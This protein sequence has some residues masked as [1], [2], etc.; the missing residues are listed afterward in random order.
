MAT[1]KNA[2]TALAK[3]ERERE[4]IRVAAAALDARERELKKA[5]SEEGAKHIAHAFSGLDLGE[6]NKAQAKQF[7]KAVKHLG[8]A[9]ALALLTAA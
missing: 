4:A 6:V 5:L 7:A 1:A 2:G 3:L 8:F 9:Q